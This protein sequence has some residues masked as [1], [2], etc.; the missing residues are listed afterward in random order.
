M[1][2]VIVGLVAVGIA[3]C[4]GIQ[5]TGTE[6]KMQQVVRYAAVLLKKS[7]DDET[8]TA[9]GNGLHSVASSLLAQPAESTC[10]PTL[11]GCLQPWQTAGSPPTSYGEKHSMKSFTGLPD[12][13]Y[14][15]TSIGKD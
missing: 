9:A 14:K 4:S 7:P 10:T 15:T 1:R 13:F 6:E 12:D 11:S 5:Y 2:G 8:V 3:G